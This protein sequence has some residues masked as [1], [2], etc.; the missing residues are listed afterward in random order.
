MRQVSRSYFDGEE[1][2]RNGRDLTAVLRCHVVSFCPPLLHMALMR[3]G[4]K[5]LKLLMGNL[6][7]GDSR[8]EGKERGEEKSSARQGTP[9]DSH[10]SSVRAGKG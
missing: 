7:G 6:G 8:E 1:A 2:A 5:D 3:L 4:C 9:A 10:G